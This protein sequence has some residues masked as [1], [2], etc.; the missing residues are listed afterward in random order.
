MYIKIKFWTSY[1]SAVISIL[2]LDELSVV[3][4]SDVSQICWS[5]SVYYAHLTLNTFTYW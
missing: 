2:S 4:D 5:T 3:V 1:L